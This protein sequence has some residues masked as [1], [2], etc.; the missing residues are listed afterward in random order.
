MSEWSWKRA[1]ADCVIRIVNREASRMF[2]FDQVWAFR[3]EF[4]QCF[5]GIDTFGKRCDRRSSAC[6]GMVFY[7]SLG[8]L[9]T[10]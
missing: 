6:A 7:F 5:P 1:V 2:T 3:D 9:F 4:A 10:N 8:M